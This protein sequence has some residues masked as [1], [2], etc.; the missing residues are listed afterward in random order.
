[1]RLAHITDTH[2]N[3]V[4]KIKRY[5]FYNSLQPYDAVIHTGDISDGLNLYSHLSEMA[6]I[7][8]KNIYFVIGNHDY[9]HSDFETIENKIQQLQTKHS[10][11]HYLNDIYNLIQLNPTTC[12]IGDNSWYDAGWRFPKTPFIFLWDWK[13]IGDFNQLET[14]KE[15]YQLMK[16]LALQSSQ[17]IFKKLTSAL[18]QYQTIYLALH[19]PPYSEGW[20]NKILTP[21]QWF[22]APYES[23]KLIART[24]EDLA[25]RN[26][27]KKII[28]LSGH[29]HIE[30]KEMI[31]PNLELIVGKAKTGKC[32]I[33]EI[34]YL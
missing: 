3:R 26:L 8:N 15:K 1:M 20:R 32:F 30:R 22:W 4:E 19:M 25:N 11:L 7:F 29:S 2:L 24:I 23:S 16:D 5:S 18:E 13:H 31:S 33:S 34:I 9:W 28:I 17:R 14:T 27:Y 12:L 6:E 10:N 21:S